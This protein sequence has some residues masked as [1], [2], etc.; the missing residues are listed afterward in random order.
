MN[1]CSPCRCCGLRETDIRLCLNLN[2]KSPTRL[3]LSTVDRTCAIS[4]SQ[5]VRH[6]RTCPLEPP[7]ELL[8]LYASRCGHTSSAPTSVRPPTSSHAVAITAIV[9][10]RDAHR[11]PADDADRRCVARV[12]VV[13]A[14][15]MIAAGS[16]QTHSMSRG[17]TSWWLARRFRPTA[18][19]L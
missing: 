7:T 17:A 10:A 16:S 8:W 5:D 15:K 14:R 12:S 1:I 6:A 19:R 13:S 4:R 18:R 9:A 11:S 3:T 2:F